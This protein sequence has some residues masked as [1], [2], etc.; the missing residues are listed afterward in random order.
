MTLIHRAALPLLA[1]SLLG[2]SGNAAVTSSGSF[3]PAT[4]LRVALTVAPDTVRTS[5]E[6]GTPL[7]LPLPA[8]LNGRSIEH[9]S[10]LRGPS[11]SG[12]AGR[13]FTWI[14]EGATPGT[15]EALLQAHAPDMPP[16]TLVVRIDF[17]P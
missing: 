11:L 8:T 12:A 9:Y 1:L 3:E 13:S 4:D 17:Q 7:V 16:D 14:P 2:L 5:A 6:P 10:L 15:H